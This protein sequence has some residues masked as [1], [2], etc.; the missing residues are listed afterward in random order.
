MN[1]SA[2]GKTMENVTKIIKVRLV[3]N[4]KDYEKYVSKPIF[5]SRKISS[6]HFVAIREIKP[7]LTLDI[8][9]YVGLSIL[10]LSKL[11]SFITS[12]LKK[13]NAYLLFTDTDSLVYKTKTDDV[14]EDFY[15]DKNLFNFTDYPQDSNLFDSVN[16][17]VIG[18]MKDEV[19]GKITKEF[20]GSKPKIYYFVDVDGEEIKKVKSFNKSVV[21]NIIH[22]EH[23]GV[24]FKIMMVKER[25]ILDVS[26]N[27]LTYFHK[28]VK[29]Q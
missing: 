11:L 17:K 4:A 6:K 2:Y 10:D 24:L 18:K 23:V 8:S 21:K 20:V 7:V 13:Y 14:Y 19:K 26:I 3:N 12:P 25:Y 15:R 9:I 27:S 1:N 29:S 22:K 16:K 5:I 28:N